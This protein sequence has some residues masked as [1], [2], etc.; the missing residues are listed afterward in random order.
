MKVSVRGLIG[1]REEDHAARFIM[2][3]PELNAILLR[4]LHSARRELVAK[5][6]CVSGHDYKCEAIV[7]RRTLG[8]S[9]ALQLKFLT[10]NSAKRNLRA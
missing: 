1:G 8:Y 6:G 10:F 3:A 7:R 4:I 9:A 2:A 5:L